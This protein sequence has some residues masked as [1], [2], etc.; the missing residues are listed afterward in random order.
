MAIDWADYWNQ[1]DKINGI[2]DG[3]APRDVRSRDS[4]ENKL[5]DNPEYIKTK[6]EGG[7]HAKSKNL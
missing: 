4:I 6:H 1:A 7:N 2:D 5:T 3:E